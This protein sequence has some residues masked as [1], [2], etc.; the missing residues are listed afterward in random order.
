MRRRG[1]ARAEALRLAEFDLRLTGF[2]SLENSLSHKSLEDRRVSRDSGV[3]DQI[4][5][6]NPAVRRQGQFRLAV[7][8]DQ[9]GHAEKPLPQTDDF[10]M[11]GL[12]FFRAEPL[13]KRAHD[14]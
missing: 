13:A 12:V 7:A 1:S 6:T 9:V 4:R 3:D 5:F 14:V 11:R 8:A 2:A 10:Q